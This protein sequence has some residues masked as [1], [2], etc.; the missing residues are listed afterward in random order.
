M[1]AVAGGNRV[2]QS[3]NWGVIARNAIG[4]PV[5]AL[6]NGSFVPGANGSPP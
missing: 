6:R 1:S 4:S 2:A 3:Q 5:A